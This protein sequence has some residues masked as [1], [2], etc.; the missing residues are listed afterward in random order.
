MGGKVAWGTN[1]RPRSTSAMSWN[2]WRPSS[3]SSGA[4]VF[5]FFILG[6]LTL[7]HRGMFL[8]VATVTEDGKIIRRLIL[9]IPISVMDV[10]P[11]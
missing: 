2:V 7:P 10:K 1:P 6:I 11:S 5:C 3:A 9:L 8:H 4:M